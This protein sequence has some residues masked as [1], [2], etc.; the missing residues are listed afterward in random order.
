VNCYPSEPALLPCVSVT[1]G[2]GGLGH[3]TFGEDYGLVTIGQEQFGA[4]GTQYRQSIAITVWTHNADLRD[5]LARRV[6]K[7]LWRLLTELSNVQGLAETDLRENGDEQDF[8]LQA[9][10]DIHMFSF[11]LLALT[12][13]VEL[14]PLGPLTPDIQVALASQQPS[15]ED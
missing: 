14:T 5:V 6:R 3:Q 9:P 7:A 1:Q 12:D 13:L 4:D 8:E 11:T 15:E 10:R 2:P